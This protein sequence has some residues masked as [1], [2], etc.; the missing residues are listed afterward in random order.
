MAS[1]ASV[2]LH[3]IASALKARG[4][5]GMK[6][7]LTAGLR[8][9]AAPLVSAVRAQAAARLP[10]E[11]GLAARVANERVTVSVLTSARNAGVTMR[12]RTHDTRATNEGYVRHLVYGRPKSWVRQ[13]IP[14]AAG[15]WS[16]TLR[17]A[18]PRVTPVLLGVMKKIAA[19]IEAA[20][21]V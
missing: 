3:A 5:R 16:D 8:A 6:R 21:R 2:Q 18:S 4:E 13:E 20:G 12:T 1:N 9:G 14:E 19:E 15:W 7:E 10:R 11:G 17:E